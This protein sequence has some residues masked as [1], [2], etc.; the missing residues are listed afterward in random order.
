MAENGTGSG[1]EESAEELLERARELFERGIRKLKE[2]GSTFEEYESTVLEKGNELQRKALQGE[3]QARSDA[4]GERL[5]IRRTENSWPRQ[6]MV[7]RRYRGGPCT[8]FTLC[9]PVSVHRYRYRS[10]E[11]GRSSIV[12]LD[13]RDRLQDTHRVAAGL[14]CC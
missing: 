12:P 4:L 5:L 10:R 7:Y 6:G 13:L 9:G 11:Y 3:L 8:Y 2:E 1:E 14:S